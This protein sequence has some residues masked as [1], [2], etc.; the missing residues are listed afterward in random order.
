MELKIKVHSTPR[1]EFGAE[2][3]SGH[4]STKEERENTLLKNLKDV[5]WINSNVQLLIM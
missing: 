1:I 5:T 2:G 3:V 4:K